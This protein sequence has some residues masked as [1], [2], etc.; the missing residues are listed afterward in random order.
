LFELQSAATAPK[1]A[2]RA[3]APQQI[4]RLR[5]ELDALKNGVKELTETQHQ[6]AYTIAAMK[7]AEETCDAMFHPRIG[8]RTRRRWTWQSQSNR[9]RPASR[10]RPDAADR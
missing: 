4:E 1:S 6:A 5:G 9:T 8:T 2:Q 10:R 7:A 3:A